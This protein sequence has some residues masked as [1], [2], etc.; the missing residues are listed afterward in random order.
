MTGGG[1]VFSVIVELIDGRTLTFEILAASHEA[2]EDIALEQANE[3]YHD[4][5]ISTVVS[6][7]A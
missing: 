5:P 6:M 7:V 2:A 4:H 1:L 3:Y